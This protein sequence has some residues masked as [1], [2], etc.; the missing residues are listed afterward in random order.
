MQRIYSVLIWTG[1]SL[2]IIFWLPLLFL[3]WLFDRDKTKYKTGRLFR[4]LGFA[5]SRINPNWNVSIEGY[6]QFDDRRPYIIVSNHLS[7]ADIPVISN[8]PWE[9][10]WVAKKELFDL[11]VVGWM[12]NMA[13]DISV[14]RSSA[15]KRLG[16]FKKCRYYLENNVSVMF[17]PEGTRSRT[18]KLK[19]FLPGAFDLAIREN[20][21]VLPIV[22]D[23]TQGCLPKKTWV[24]KPDVFVKLKV[25]TPVDTSGFSQGEADKLMSAVRNQMIAQLAEWRQV[26]P[27][28]LDATAPLRQADDV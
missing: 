9:M 25:L 15:G 8:L 17:F 18:G 22:L 27:E 10:K 28:E 26:S 7:N 24:F 12:M 6:Q 3:R 19:R 23:G 16:V 11:P 13:G 14:D 20:I 5:I 21:P 1:I 4:K 2:L